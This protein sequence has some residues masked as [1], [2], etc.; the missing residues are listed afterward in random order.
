MTIYADNRLLR[1]RPKLWILLFSALLVVHESG[2]AIPSSAI[3]D[4]MEEY[5][6]Q[7][8]VPGV[9]VGIDLKGERWLGAYGVANLET[10][11]K[12]APEFQFRIASVTKTFTASTIL[13]LIELGKLS[14]TDTVEK[15]LPGKI[16]NGENITIS[17]LLNHT[18]GLYDHENTQEEEDIL[19]N[20]PT[21]VWTEEDVIQL[22]NQYPPDFAPGAEYSY[23]NSGY[24]LLG[25]IAEKA[26]NDTVDNLTQKYLFTPAGMSRTRLTREGTLTAPDTPGYVRYENSESLSNQ[27]AMSLTWD[28]TAGSGV[29]TV[30]DL[31]SFARALSSGKI[32]NAESFRQMTTPIPPAKTYGYGLEISPPVS[33]GEPFYGHNGYNPGAFAGWFA[34]PQSDCIISFGINYTDYR[35]ATMINYMYSWI[36]VLIKIHALIAPSHSAAPANWEIYQ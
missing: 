5:A 4:Q 25:M 16:K 36:N 10:G 11:E 31:I 1:R 14:L 8:N 21:Y 35:R 18:S 33:F 19:L 24:Y 3:Q 20:N 9:I 12:M 22:I 17:M 15:W 2:A 28:W 23:C 26:A 30:A 32:V 29:S 7:F 27:G 13:K 34:F 6:R